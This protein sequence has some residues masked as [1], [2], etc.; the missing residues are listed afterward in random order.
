VCSDREFIR[1]AYLDGIGTLPTPVEVE[2]FVAAENPGKREALVDELLGLTGD[3][4]RDRFVD[5][6]SAYWTLKLGDLLR[7]SR[8]NGIGEGG[9]WTFHNWIRGSLREGK[10]FDHFAR[11]VITAQ[12][13]IFDNG[14]ANYYRISQNSTDLAETTAQ[15][16]L[17]IRLQCARC[18]HHPFEVYSQE[19]YYS[20]AA[21]FTRVDTKKSSEFGAADQDRVVLVKDSGSI[22][23][24]RTGQVLRPKPLLADPIDSTGIRDL[25]RP[26]SEWLTAPD[27]PLFSRNIANRMWG[28]VMG[29]GI[30][31]P[32]DDLRATNPPSNPEL[33]D[34]LAEDFV[35]SG[36]DL[37]K[38]M[39]AIMVSRTYQ[40]SSTPRPENMVLV[41]YGTHFNVKRLPAEVLLDA[42]DSVCGTQERFPGLPK[43]TRA[44]ELPDSNYQSYFLDTLGRPKRAVSC[45]CERTVDPNLA[46]VLQLANGDLINRKISDD[47]G[48]IAVMVKADRSDA[49]IVTEL[50][51]RAMSRP[52]TDE[53]LTGC[54]AIISQAENRRVGLEDVLWALLNSREFLF[55]H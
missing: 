44:I 42:I 39:R 4:E 6:W 30:V 54:A 10:P 23:H 46:Q 22:R 48:R 18:H 52:P 25:R 9:M 16:F 19:D 13:S 34:A 26:L 21:F 33:L 14:P 20:L 32:I 50:Y 7:N 35:A 2:A 12:G 40:L 53:E 1:R 49:E 31:E 45:E 28:Y 11:E 15:V 17:G 27:N 41:R 43:G 8:Q 29:K 24:P 47:A 55:N 36:Y 51:Q 3:P 37:R 5:Q 38:L